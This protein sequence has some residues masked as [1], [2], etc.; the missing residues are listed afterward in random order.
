MN[1][2][3]GID[4]VTRHALVDDGESKLHDETD[5][6]GTLQP[7]LPAEWRLIRRLLL[8]SGLKN[9]SLPAEEVIF[10]IL[11]FFRSPKRRNCLN[12]F[13]PKRFVL[14]FPQ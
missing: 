1:G 2:D 9:K 12:V 4:A 6:R 3:G 10:V 7:L 13:H 8:G 5:D 14:N 11:K